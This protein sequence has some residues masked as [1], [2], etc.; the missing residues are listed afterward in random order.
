MLLFPKTFVFEY[1][2]QVLKK[3]WYLSIHTGYLD[4]FPF[5]KMSPALQQY[6]KTYMAEF[7]HGPQFSLPLC[8]PKKKTD[9]TIII[10]I[11][12]RNNLI[13][14]ISLMWSFI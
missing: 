5:H 9:G 1:C 12:S 10:S 8:T 7:Y 6:I 11:N 3:G 13:F 4:T 14:V 2:F